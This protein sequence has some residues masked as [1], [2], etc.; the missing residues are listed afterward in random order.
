[1]NK[2][3][4]IKEMLKF[5]NEQGENAF[6]YPVITFWYRDESCLRMFISVRWVDETPC[7]AV[8]LTYESS[9][10]STETPTFET[11][12]FVPFLRKTSLKDDLNT[13][14]TDLISQGINIEKEVEKV[15]I[16]AI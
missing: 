6:N 4:I 15:D 10:K 8:M 1:M 5:W 9:D 7:G 12:T 14:L 3:D 11:P 13:I 2:N 16:L